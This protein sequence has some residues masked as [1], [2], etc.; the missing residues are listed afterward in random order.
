M[1]EP[2]E[3]GLLSLRFLGGA[4]DNHQGTRQD[5]AVVGRASGRGDARLYILVERSG[6]LDRSAAA[7]HHFGGFGG[8]LPSRLGCTGL[9]DDRPALDRAARYS[10]GR[11]P[12]SAHLYDRAHASCRD[13]RR[14]HSPGRAATHRPPNCP[15]DRSRR[16]GTHAPADSVRRAR[17]APSARNSAPRPGWRS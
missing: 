16:N 8:E 13:R 7:E 9:D 3:Q 4:S 1:Y 17:H 10:A 2:V 11:A 5:F 12:T 15:K 14:C 6:F